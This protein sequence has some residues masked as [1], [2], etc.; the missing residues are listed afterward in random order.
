MF[1]LKNNNLFVQKLFIVVLTIC[2]TILFSTTA[3]AYSA[4]DDNYLVEADGFYD[5]ATIADGENINVRLVITSQPIGVFSDSNVKV[6]VGTYFDDNAP[7][8]LITYPSDGT[9]FSSTNIPIIYYSENESLV[10]KY[11]VK[12]DASEWV[13][14]GLNKGYLFSNL[15]IGRH[16]FYVKAV[17]VFGL[18]GQSLVTIFIREQ[19][20]G[21]TGGG[22]SGG[23]GGSIRTP[24]VIDITSEYAQEFELI[25]NEMSPTSLNELGSDY[26]TN[27]RIADADE[28]KL[29]RTIKTR[30]V[31][32]GED[33]ISTDFNFQID[34]TNVSGRDLE[35][36]SIIESIPKQ[37]AL[38]SNKINFANAPNII[39]ADPVVEWTF[40][41]LSFGAS[42]SENYSI[43][44]V[45]D[46]NI[47]NDLNLFL[48]NLSTPTPIIPLSAEDTLCGSIDCEDNNPCTEDYCV[49]GNCFYSSKNGEMCGN[50]GVC[51]KTVCKENNLINDWEEFNKKYDNLI[52]IIVVVVILLIVVIVGMFF[53]VI[54]SKR[55]NKTKQDS[56]SNIVQEVLPPKQEPKRKNKTKK[57]SKHKA[58]KKTT[59]PKNK[60]KI[61]KSSKKKK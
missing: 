36:V 26:L 51:Q 50:G 7:S 22:T 6:K 5:S 17:D 21:D 48:S 2:L 56:K 19:S 8:V 37:L 15:S 58:V 20:T 35:N 32:M 49:K 38:D 46:E 52:S 29:V 18:I 55:K 54:H 45:Y 24:D 44:G 43:N 10:T 9:V 53:F 42:T 4:F 1:R 11:Y 60:P 14:N 40:P 33:V 16:V 59:R 34:I 61:K 12:L 57:E 39:R 27:S 3:F 28:I 23:A 31:R 41:I 30:V 13:D 47:L 25:E